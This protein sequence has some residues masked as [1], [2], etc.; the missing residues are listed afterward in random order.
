MRTVE[1]VIL[2]KIAPITQKTVAED[3]G[4]N[5]TNLSR[6]LSD[7]G[8]RLSFPE[9]CALLDRIGITGDALAAAVG[10]D[11]VV[12]IAR[13]EYDSLRFFARKGIGG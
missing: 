2:E 3:I 8:H 5:N 7:K 6:Y 12:V 9:V 10:S 4:V 13:E 11:R 1:S